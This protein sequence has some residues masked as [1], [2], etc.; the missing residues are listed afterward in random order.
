MP[1][2]TTPSPVPCLPPSSTP[3]LTEEEAEIEQQ[4]V[5]EFVEQFKVERIKFGYSPADVNQQL[6]IRYGITFPAVTIDQFE[7]NQLSLQ[8]MISTTKILKCW[9][10]DMVR[11]SGMAEKKVQEL[12]EIV[13]PPRRELKK[14]TIID[15]H[16]KTILDDEF[17]KNEKPSPAQ[18]TEIAAKI[19][20]E[21][22]VIKIW[23]ANQRQRRKQQEKDGD[24]WVRNLVPGFNFEPDILLADFESQLPMLDLELDTIC[25]IKNT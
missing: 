15:E 19:G 1:S 17:T 5:K 4:R 25:Q 16:T 14:R 13:P 23:F 2:A 3:Q 11:A 6:A 7:A 9:I 20:V 22:N 10:I 12:F 8:E 24:T 21:R 18:Q